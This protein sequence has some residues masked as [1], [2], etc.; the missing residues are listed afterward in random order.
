M[1]ERF[2]S[3]VMASSYWDAAASGNN[4]I[5]SEQ[6]YFK[7]RFN[8][9]RFQD[10]VT[11]SARILDFGCGY[12]RILKILDEAGFEN[13]IGIDISRQMLARAQRENPM[14]QTQHYDGEHIPFVEREFDAVICS[15]VLNTVPDDVQLR[16]IFNEFS[17]VLKPGGILYLYE[18]LCAPFARDVAR[19]EDFHTQ[20]PQ[21]P[22][23]LFQH[24]SGAIMRH[25]PKE[26]MQDFL[27]P[28]FEI[29][30][31]DQFEFPTMNDNPALQAEWVAKALP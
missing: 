8:L 22:Y 18:F 4:A 19:F 11:P 16:Q 2:F 9:S 25:F 5:F 30:H 12:G 3:P 31:F 6:I 13:A 23:G 28:R 7:D 10:L 15:T 20:H 21:T 29:I 24:P 14:L 27:E 26:V 1:A 17:R